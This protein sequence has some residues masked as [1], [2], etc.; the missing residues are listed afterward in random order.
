MERQILGTV[1]VEE[2]EGG[3]EGAVDAGGRVEVQEMA[4]KGEN[5]DGAQA[6]GGRQLVA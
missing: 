6:G 1:W 5:V 4:Y 3:G 2:G